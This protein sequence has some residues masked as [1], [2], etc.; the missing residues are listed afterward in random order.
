MSVVVLVIRVLS[1][2]ALC[3]A[4]AERSGDTPNMPQAQWYLGVATVGYL[5]AERFSKKANRDD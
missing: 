4:F 3:R 2:F 5:L 1:T